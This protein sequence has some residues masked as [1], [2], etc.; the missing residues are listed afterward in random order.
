M[1][2]KFKKALIREIYYYLLTL[3]ILAM[4]M[5]IDLLSDP[6]ARVAM[7]QE[8]ENY[9]HPLLYAFVI[10]IIIFTIRKIIDFIMGLFGKKS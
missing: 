2:E 1:A 9:F 3:C 10:Y 7:M 4:M 6:L 5:H 8:K